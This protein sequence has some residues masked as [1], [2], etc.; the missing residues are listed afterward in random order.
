M[1]FSN[2]FNMTFWAVICV[3]FWGIAQLGEVMVPSADH[4]VLGHHVHKDTAVLWST[5]G[6]AQSVSIHTPW[7]KTTQ[8]MGATLILT[9]KDN[10]TCPYCAIQQQ[11]LTN[12]ALPSNAHFFG[13]LTNDGWQPMVK[14]SVTTGC[15]EI[16][17]RF[18]L[19]GPSGHSFHIGSTT[20]HLTQGT[21]DKV[22]QQLGQWTSDAFYIYWH[23]MQA[24]IL[25]HIHNAACCTEIICEVNTFLLDA[26][27]EVKMRWKE[28]EKT[29]E[30]MSSTLPPARKKARTT[31]KTPR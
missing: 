18:G 29:H 5:H 15:N 31:K 4:F 25:L 12:A 7:T 20:H 23:N 30:E 14:Q 10:C 26:T 19:Q 17:T 16:W 22:V 21:D 27:P 28:I 8:W 1:D 6:H 11:Q 13:F 3:A 9:Y 2:S 24:I